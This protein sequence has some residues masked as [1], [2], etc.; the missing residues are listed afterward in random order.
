ML[1]RAVAEEQ[2]EFSPSHFSRRQGLAN[3]HCQSRGSESAKVVVSGG[4]SR[5]AD[6]ANGIA[7]VAPRLTLTP[8]FQRVFQRVDRSP[9]F[10]ASH[11]SDHRLLDIEDPEKPAVSC[12]MDLSTCLQ[13][14][15]R[16]LR[17]RLRD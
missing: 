1:P 11:P 10:P 16:L 6:L 2:C 3:D 4:A 5:R 7:E 14:N 15:Q 12:V 9:P 13:A 8:L 17:V